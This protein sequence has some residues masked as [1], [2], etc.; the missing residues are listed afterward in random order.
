MAALF[1]ISHD[2][3]H[4][5]RHEI[6]VLHCEHR[7]FNADHATNF[8]RPETAAVH[9][10]FGDDRALIGDNIPTA[11]LALVQFFD[12]C[13]QIDF[14]T[15]NTRRLRIGMRCAVRIEIAVGLVEH[16]ADEFRFIKQR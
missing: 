1:V 14:S 8:A 10:M 12:L 5:I 16:R 7:Q 9:N 15:L 4:L 3:R 13:F 6:H 11:I 2:F